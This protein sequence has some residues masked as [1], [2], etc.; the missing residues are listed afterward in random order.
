MGL[1]ASMHMDD[2]P[3]NTPRSMSLGGDRAAVTQ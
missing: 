3:D 2:R 1:I